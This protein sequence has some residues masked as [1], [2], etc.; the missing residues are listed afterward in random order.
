[1]AGISALEGRARKHFVI[2]LAVLLLASL[3]LC[4]IHLLW[5]DEDYH[6]AAALNILHGKLPYRDFWYDKP[7]LSA[8]Y[9]LIIGAH[10]GWL[11]RLLDTGYVLLA[12]YLIC[13]LARAWWGEHEGRIA[14]LLLAFFMA[15]YLP[16]AVLPFAAD[17]LMLV[18]HV[19]AIYFAFL[20][21]PFLAGLF[22]AVA[23]LVN[24]KALFVLAVC[25]AWLLAS[26]PALLLGFLAPLLAAFASAWA[27]G[28]WSGYCE[29]VWRWGWIY[30]SQSPVAHPLHSALLRTADWLGFHSALAGGTT[31]TLLRTTHRSRWMLS[32]WIALSF[33]S[34]CLGA[35][36]EPRYFLQLLPALVLAGSR[37]VVIGYE[38][39]R[40][41]TV[42]LLFATLLVPLIRFGPHYVSLAYDDLQNRQPAWTDVQLD[43]DSQAAASQ[44]NSAAQAGD[45]LFVWGYRPD[46]YVYTRLTSDSKFWDSQPLTG[47]PADR[48]LHAKK[49][50]YGGPAALNRQQLA[51]TKP[52]WLVDGLGPLNPNLRPENYP[53]L[54]DW[55]TYYEVV[56]RTRF[57]VLYHRLKSPPLRSR[58]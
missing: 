42:V 26:L 4:H 45:T 37:G 40:R 31:V 53:E 27:A 25:A 52:T 10:P 30:A 18:P 43:L 39:Y 35:R 19:A 8:V 24:P 23:F 33:A 36:F 38:S 50:I 55:L 17:A 28:C 54:R 1:M 7:P 46:I 22:C 41:S 14:A 21:R 3:R 32:S 51:G 57:C 29:Q 20:R 56:G 34:V 6:L 13:R 44:I 48:H 11:L 12:C 49:A 16:S 47:V 15:F 58:F 9:Y 5:A 2:G